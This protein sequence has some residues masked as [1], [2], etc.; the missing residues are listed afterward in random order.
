MSEDNEKL[1]ILVH[2]FDSTSVTLMCVNLLSIQPFWYLKELT[3]FPYRW[4]A[5]P[6]AVRYEVQVAELTAEPDS[7]APE[8]SP[9]IIWT[10]I[11]DSIKSSSVRKKNLKPFTNYVARV[12]FRDSIDWASFSRPCQFK[13]LEVIISRRAV[14]VFLLIEELHGRQVVDG[15]NHL[16]CIHQIP[17][18]SRLNGPQSNLLGHTQS[19][20][21]SALSAAVNTTGSNFLP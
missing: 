4:T 6:T 13:T 9:D 3:G 15:C 16:F 17:K 21:V 11:S 20:F 19:C 8:T 2:D 1:E 5:E 7:S 14:A 12:R 18:V 10:S